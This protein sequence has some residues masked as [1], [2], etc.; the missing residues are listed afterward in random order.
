MVAP[1]NKLP[2]LL[3]LANPI[4]IQEVEVHLSQNNKLNKLK[5]RST[6]PHQKL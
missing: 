4:K 3:S 5:V 1:A 6:I 2:K